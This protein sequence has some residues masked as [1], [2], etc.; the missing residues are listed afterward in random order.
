MKGADNLREIMSAAGNGIGGGGEIAYR[1]I[2]SPHNE[3][4]Y[5]VYI[6]GHHSA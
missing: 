4:T 1:F 5:Q 2:T 3:D 6:D